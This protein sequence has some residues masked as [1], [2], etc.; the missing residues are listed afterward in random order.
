M[1]VP[2]TPEDLVV[3]EF[4]R[5]RGRLCGLIESWGLPEKQERGAI[6]TLKSLTYDS[7]KAITEVISPSPERR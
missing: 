5:I 3:E 4:N 2:E 1:P 6:Q 7:Q